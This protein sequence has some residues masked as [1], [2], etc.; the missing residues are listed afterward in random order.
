MMRKRELRISEARGGAALPV[1]VIPRSDRNEISGWQADVLKVRLTAA[2]VEGAANEALTKLLA[3]CL[4]VPKSDI[5][6]IKG[7]SSRHKLVCIIGLSPREVDERIA[8]C[9][10]NDG[11]SGDGERALREDGAKKR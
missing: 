9:I 3:K 5:E 2:P 8:N 11:A 10:G 7:G 6:I 1:H 4:D